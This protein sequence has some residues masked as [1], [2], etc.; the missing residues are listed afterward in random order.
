[1]SATS[2]WPAVLAALRTQLAARPGY[3]LPSDTAA[4]G[5][6]TVLVGSEPNAVTDPGDWIALGV[7]EDE[8]STA[9]A[10]SQ[11]W[12]TA[13]PGHRGRDEVGE[14]EVLISVLDGSPDRIV[15]MQRAFT[16]LAGLELVIAGAPDLGLAPSVASTLVLNPPSGGSVAWGDGERGSRCLLRATITYRARLTGVS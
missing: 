7:S 2:L 14:I 1:M 12:R 4:S 15:T 9:G 16:A 5:S 6:V 13:G 11:T 3:R 10:W 8:G